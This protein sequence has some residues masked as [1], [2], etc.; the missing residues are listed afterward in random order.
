MEG[1]MFAKRLPALGEYKISTDPS[2]TASRMEK[3]LP[4]HLQ[5][6]AQNFN[7]LHEQ[8]TYFISTI[9]TLTYLGIGDRATVAAAWGYVGIRIVHSLVHALSNRIMVRFNL[10]AASSAVLLGLTVRTAAVVFA[11][12]P[13]RAGVSI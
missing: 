11:S 10:F 9:L 5:W 12:G 8:P 2:F 3:M 7:H 6:A 4:P 13:G 1:W